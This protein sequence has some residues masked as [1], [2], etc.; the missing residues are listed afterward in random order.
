VVDAKGVAIAQSEYDPS[1][2]RWRLDLWSGGG[3]AATDYIEAPNGGPSLLG[4]G[5]D[6]ASI[7][8]EFGS[9]EKDVVRELSPD[10][11]KLG[12]PYPMEDSDSLFWDPA[13]YKLVAEGLLDG[14]VRRWRFFDAAD[15]KAWEGVTKALG[16]PAAE[17]V[18]LSADH[19]RLVA[20][21]D[22]ATEGPAY[23]LVDTPS[24]KAQLIGKEYAGLGPAGIAE[25]RPIAFKAADG[26]ALTGYLTLPHDRAATRL[27]LVAFPHGGPAAR[28]APGFDWWAQAMASRGYAVLQVNFRGSE[29]LSWAL[30]SAGF[31]EWGRKMQTDL[32]DGVRYLARQGLIDPARVCIVGASYGGYA[33]LAGVTLDPGV[34]RCAASVAGVSDLPRMVDYDR[35]R[36]SHKGVLAQRYWTRFIGDKARMEAVSPDKLAAKVTV[37]VLLVHGRDDTVVPYQQSQLM[38]DALARAGKPF[39]FVTLK[40]EDHWLSRGATRLEML[41]AVVAFLE[42]NDPPGAGAR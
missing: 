12:D 25:V 10:G 7:A 8:L 22:S 34:Y 17:L 5:R 30:E 9:D 2:S 19:H 38:A 11:A 26:L 18:S 16:D 39:E 42:K 14:D 4:L 24:D 13:T 32:S 40:G 20:R 31:G 35:S 37:P 27:P 15:Q 21:T 28:D 1:K 33:A 6:G 41:E 23:Y 3:W 36:E 29:G